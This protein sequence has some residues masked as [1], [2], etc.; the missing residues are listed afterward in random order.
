LDI[1]GNFYS[2]SGSSRPPPA[3]KNTTLDEEVDGEL[4]FADV[5]F[6]L[7][8]KDEVSLSSNG[9][10]G[11]L[12][13]GK[14]PDVVVHHAGPPPTPPRAV[15]RMGAAKLNGGKANPGHGEVS[16]SALRLSAARLASAVSSS[17][18][19]VRRKGSYDL[20][21]MQ[22]STRVAG[23]TYD[24]FNGRFFGE[25]FENS[26]PNAQNGEQHGHQRRTIVLASESSGVAEESVIL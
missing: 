13:N 21:M 22:M 1:K 4:K 6:G 19:N 17:A 9:L 16:A 14:R 5:S 8:T 11:H 24:N 26:P 3:F 20:E 2:H 12:V 7:S 15:P 10:S 23:N 25:S 18:L